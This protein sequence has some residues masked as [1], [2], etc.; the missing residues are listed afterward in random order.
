MNNVLLVTL[1]ILACLACIGLAL[2]YRKR[3]KMK[4]V[5]TLEEHNADM[6]EEQQDSDGFNP[7]RFGP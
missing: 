1:I 2:W 4:Y 3:T 6:Y 7:D 5:Q